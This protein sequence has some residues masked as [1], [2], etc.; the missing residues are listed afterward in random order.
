ME[1]R[2]YTIGGETSAFS[3]IANKSTPIPVVVTSLQKRKSAFRRIKNMFSNKCACL[4]AG[5]LRFPAP[6]P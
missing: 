1:N 5:N 6:L 3:P 2:I 4:T